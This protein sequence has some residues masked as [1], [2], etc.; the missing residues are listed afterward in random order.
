[1]KKL[2]NIAVIVLFVMLSFACLIPL[3]A[4]YNYAVLQK[5]EYLEIYQ[6]IKDVAIYFIPIILSI[7]GI[8][9]FNLKK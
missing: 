9:T 7:V 5:Q 4:L 8:G 3:F 1:M 6:N 2:K